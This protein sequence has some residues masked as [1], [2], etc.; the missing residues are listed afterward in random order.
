MRTGRAELLGFK[1]T[2]TR[3][4]AQRLEP[5]FSS[6]R[7]MDRNGSMERFHH[8]VRPTDAGRLKKGGVSMLFDPVFDEATRPEVAVQATCRHGMLELLLPL[9]DSAKPRR[10]EIDVAPESKQLQAA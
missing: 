1:R 4:S 9:K 10:I 8:Q 5:G 3:Y 7:H 2:M 6:D